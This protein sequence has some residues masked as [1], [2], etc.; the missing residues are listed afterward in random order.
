MPLFCPECESSNPK[1]GTYCTACGASLQPATPEEDAPAPRRRKTS[2]RSAGGSAKH[3]IGSAA[4]AIARMRL[5]FLAIGTMSALAF[6]IQYL[7]ID[8]GAMDS[9]EITVLVLIGAPAVICFAG[10]W[11]GQRN[12]LPWALLLAT[13]LTVNVAATI[14]LIG[15]IPIVGILMM[16]AAW[17]YVPPI[18][19]F[20]RLIRENPDDAELKALL[21]GKVARTGRRH[22]SL[23]SD[24]RSAA[25]IF[26]GLVLLVIGGSYAMSL[27]SAAS[28]QPRSAGD[29]VDEQPSEPIEPMLARFE[30]AWKNSDVDAIGELYEPRLRAKRARRLQR[31]FDSRDMSGTLPPLGERDHAN[32]ARM[33]K[34]AIW[35]IDAGEVEAIFEFS[36]GDWW[37]IA[38]RLPD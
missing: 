26:I 13:W 27:T 5:F 37:M 12:P 22:G 9:T 33:K 15:S 36:D 17:G 30:Q 8:A 38:L 6:A 11:L 7:Q 35:E 31:R 32:Y 16:L 23:L 18:L 19:A 29:T 4:R 1:D 10:C 3:R 24:F 34:I 20:Q 25:M 2:R 21:E 28:R 14:L